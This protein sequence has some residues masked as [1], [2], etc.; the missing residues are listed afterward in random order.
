MAY[1]EKINT[2]IKEIVS[3]YKGKLNEEDIGADIDE[4]HKRCWHCG[5]ISK[6]YRCHIIPSS[7]GGQDCPSNYVLLCRRCH[8]QAPN[9]TDE[10][11]MM[12]WLKN[13]STKI[14]DIYWGTQIYKLY[15]K[16]YHVNFI[17]E[18]NIR[19]ALDRKR[20]QK[21][22]YSKFN[23]IKLHIGSGHFNM[24]TWVGLFKMAFDDFDN[25]VNFS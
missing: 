15:N 21:I 6:L 13:D 16:I 25:K 2:T 23:D 14:Y 8:E 1:H 22:L 12:H 7:A 5:D 11:I 4:I 18:Y 20:L 3:Y 24:S 17:D 10:K 19:F 9:C